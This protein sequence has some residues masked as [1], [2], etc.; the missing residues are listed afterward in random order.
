LLFDHAFADY[1]V[2]GGLDERGGDGLA[3]AAAF[4][5]VGLVGDASGVGA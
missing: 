2:D 3:G 5:V 1:L 4:A